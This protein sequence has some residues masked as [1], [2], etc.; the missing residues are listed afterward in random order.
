MRG[1]GG[2][3]GPVEAVP[4]VLGAPA[5]VG[6]GPDRDVAQ[7]ASGV[8]V[9]GQE[10][11]VAAGVDDVR[12][13][14]SNRDVAG[15]ATAD[16][17]PLR[18]GDGVVVGA[19]GH[20]HR[21]VVLLGAVDAVGRP[22]VDRDVV[23]LSGGLVVE[24]GPGEATVEGDG[25]AAVVPEDHPLGIRGVD[26]EV[27]VVAV[28]R[29][30]LLEGLTAVDG[31]KQLDVEAPDRVRVLGIGAEVG[32]VPGA[33]A[34]VALLVQA[35]PGLAAV[36]GAEDAALLVLHDRP[37]AAGLG[38]GGGDPDLALDPLRHPG[39]VRK[40]GPGV[41]AV[42][43]SPEARAGAAAA[44]LVG[45][46][47]R[48]PEGSVDDPGV[49]RVEREIDRTGVLTPGE[50]EVPG[51]ATVRGAV[52]AALGVGAVGVAESSDVDEIRVGG[53]DADL[54]D[55]AGA[56]QP[57]VAPGA[58]G[59]GG[60][61]DAVAVGDV[62]ADG[63]FAHRGVDDVRI[64]GAEGQPADGCALEE[65]VGDVFPILAAVGGLP[66]SAAGRAEVKNSDTRG[67]SGDGDDA[68]AAVGTDQAPLEPVERIGR[69]VLAILGV[70]HVASLM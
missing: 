10:A 54:A 1:E 32:V 41:T 38:G 44:Q 37:D 34:E 46:S 39:L 69:R 7:L 56:L 40:V 48:L 20:A 68:A 47:A 61:V 33:L 23:E 18:Q 2:R 22:G 26:P 45:A 15:L 52:D 63:R 12:V 66:D 21:G 50:D 16:F 36:V 58:A 49:G 13:V 35:L 24:G 53:V 42:G 43:G 6:L 55:V 31:A 28:G 64:G 25:A 29:R 9:A 19:A 65:A 62:A 59:V 27:V 11:L 30:Y 17:V 5:G 51:L 4:E 57:E 14:R 60:A 8:V 70:R 67:V 3:R